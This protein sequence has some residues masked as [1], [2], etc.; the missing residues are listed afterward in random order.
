MHYGFLFVTWRGISAAVKPP[1]RSFCFNRIYLLIQITLYLIL[2]LC[3]PSCSL[4]IAH[5][6]QIFS[7]NCCVPQLESPC[8]FLL[9]PPKWSCNRPWL[10]H[11]QSEILRPTSHV[12]VC[13]KIFR[14]PLLESVTDTPPF[15]IKGSIMITI[16]H[17]WSSPQGQWKGPE[18]LGFFQV[19]CEG[20]LGTKYFAWTWRGPWD[21]QKWEDWH[22]YNYYL[23]EVLKAPL[24]FYSQWK[25]FILV[26]QKYSIQYV[27]P[28][29]HAIAD[30]LAAFLDS[31]L[32]YFNWLSSS[33]HQYAFILQ[34]CQ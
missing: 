13:N 24:I 6:N 2:I 27:L 20:C 19:L 8:P 34:V 11:D 3:H 22:Y 25:W 21:C 7:K 15:Y 18:S 10:S 4:H 14:Q 31:V 5:Y 9:P 30:C 32:K 17:I 29:S 12:P 28:W 26:P 33:L 23:G 16:L 1:R